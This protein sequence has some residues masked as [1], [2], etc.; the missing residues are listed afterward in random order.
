MVVSWSPCVEMEASVMSEAQSV[1]NSIDLTIVT[2][3]PSLDAN[4]MTFDFAEQQYR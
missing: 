4:D 2:D 3:P 1:D